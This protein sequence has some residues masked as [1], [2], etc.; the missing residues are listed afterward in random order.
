M[1]TFNALVLVVWLAVLPSCRDAFTAN[2][3]VVARAGPWELT[4][5]RRP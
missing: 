2:V 1:K 5:D 4:V 3:S